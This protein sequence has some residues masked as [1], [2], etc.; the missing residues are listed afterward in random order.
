[1]RR[2][3]RTVAAVGVAAALGVPATAIAWPGGDT[4]PERSINGAATR[5]T[6]P[7]G[8]DIDSLGLIYVA[9]RSTDSIAVFAPSATGD[10][11]PVKVLRGPSTLLSFPTGVA[12]DAADNLH[13]AN[14]TGAIT[15]YDAGWASGDTA[16]SH[17]IEGPTSLV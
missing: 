10:V 8:I 15:R 9:D 16:P 3:L 4:P 7:I 1:M 11:A 5:L 13:V 6:S 17:V 2:I 12:I 14:S